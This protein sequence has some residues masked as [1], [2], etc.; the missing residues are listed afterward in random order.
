[1]L[2]GFAVRVRT[3]RDVVA[4]VDATSLNAR[5]IILAVVVR[6]AFALAGRDSRAT[7]AVGIAD[8]ALRT[9]AH[10]IA[11]RVDAVRAVTARIVRAFVHVDATVLRIA[12]ET[13]L[14]HASRRIARRAF[15][16][17]AAR[18]TIA[19]ICGCFCKNITSHKVEMQN[20]QVALETR[21]L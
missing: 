4:R 1:M 9:L 21:Y 19:R 16:V 18:E 2:V 13:G 3:A 15:R 7:G 11:F 6:R 20:L 14:A 8:H 5:Q 12:F 17:N 10:V